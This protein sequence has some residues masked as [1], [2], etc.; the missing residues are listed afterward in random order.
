MLA[1]AV[2]MGVFTVT[3]APTGMFERSTGSDV[4]T[5]A[6]ASLMMAVAWSTVAAGSPVGTLRGLTALITPPTTPWAGPGSTPAAAPATVMVVK[7][8]AVAMAALAA[9]PAP[10]SLATIAERN[11]GM[12]SSFLH[13]GSPA[14][15][16]AG[17][18]TLLAAVASRSPLS[19]ERPDPSIPAPR[20]PERSTA[21]SRDPV[22]VPVPGWRSAR[23]GRTGAASLAGEVGSSPS[24]VSPS[25]VALSCPS[26]SSSISSW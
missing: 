14:A 22:R 21:S 15:C 5:E 11:V 1:P 2:P 26:Q 10:T 20:K 24:G 16:G 13:F 9:V 8:V 25:G 19:M 3:S 17:P 23:P 18:W 7:T 12:V 6:K 4:G